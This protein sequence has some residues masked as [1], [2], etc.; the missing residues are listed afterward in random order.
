MGNVS[1]LQSNSGAYRPFHLS[2]SEMLMTRRFHAHVGEFVKGGFEWWVIRLGMRCVS[3][4]VCVA[5]VCVCCV[6]RR[7]RMRNRGGSIHPA[8]G[9]HQIPRPTFLETR[10]SV[11]ASA[12]STSCTH[13]EVLKSS[14]FQS[15]NENE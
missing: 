12:V 6:L 4:L 3:G 2:E 7:M 13:L 15:E 14:A 10:R 9:S 5:C 8:E 11:A 1:S